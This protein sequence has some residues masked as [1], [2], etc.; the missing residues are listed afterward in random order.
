MNQ[1]LLKY[2]IA[3]Q[4]NQLIKVII[5]KNEKILNIAGYNPVLLLG[6]VKDWLKQS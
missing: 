3:L 6:I 5:K 1:D 4:P 2:Y